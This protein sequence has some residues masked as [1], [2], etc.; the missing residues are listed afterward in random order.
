M[1]EVEILNFQKH[2]PKYLCY[3]SVLLRNVTH[4][5]TMADVE[6]WN[7]FK[8]IFQSV[9]VTAMCYAE[10][11]RT[12]LR[13][14]KLKFGIFKDIFKSVLCYGNMVRRNVTHPVTPP[15]RGYMAVG[16]HGG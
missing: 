5:V 6:I 11:L 4:P 7:F 14:P 16:G 12:Q 3:F 1:A 10:M 13:L 8:D 9:F 15:V 2:L